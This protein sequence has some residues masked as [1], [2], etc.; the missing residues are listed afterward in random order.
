MPKFLQY[1]QQYTPTHGDILDIAAGT[2]E[3]TI[4]LLQSGYRVV[5]L[6]LHRGM[7]RQLTQK[8]RKYKLASTTRVMDM[9]ELSLEATFD[10][11]CIRQAINYCMGI[12]ELKNCLY[13][14]H[15]VLKM[16]GY[17]IFNTPLYTGQRTYPTVH[18]MYKV[19]GTH[20]F[21]L[22]KNELDQRILTHRQ[23]SII[24][25][26]KQEPLYIQD[27]NTF[28]MFTK[29]ELHRALKQADFTSITFHGNK[30]SLY[31]IAQT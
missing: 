22:E 13:G 28:Y 11:V 6:D 25:S 31:C 3:V 12:D 16:G 21:V 14:I 30:K 1:V 10:T 19:D 17:C 24:W 5:S 9:K 7:L 2:G 20:A 15:K 27:E 18:N 29:T 23:H 4:P 26:D 8:A